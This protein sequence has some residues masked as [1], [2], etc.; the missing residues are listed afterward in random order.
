MLFFADGAYLLGYVGSVIV[1]FKSVQV[2]LVNNL[3]CLFKHIGVK[4][5]LVEY[6]EHMFM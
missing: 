4:L 6:L 2:F 3:N 1:A 5:A